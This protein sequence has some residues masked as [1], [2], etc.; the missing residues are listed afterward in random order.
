MATFQ[1]KF[2]TKSSN[3]TS[4][5]VQGTTV[6]ASNA[7]EAKNKVKAQHAHSNCR[8]ISCVKTGN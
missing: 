5:G 7:M 8:I 2:E 6:S 1:V 3:G 4:S